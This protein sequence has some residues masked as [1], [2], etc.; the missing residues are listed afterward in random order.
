MPAMFFRV[1]VALL[2]SSV[3]LYSCTK[4]DIPVNDQTNSGAGNNGN[5]ATIVYNVNKTTILQLVND[6]RKRGCTC[7]TTTMPAV[8]AVVWN[9]QLAKA[10]L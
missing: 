10:R 3:L 6:V 2:F 7:G 5:T 4:T 8:G 1:I 9:D